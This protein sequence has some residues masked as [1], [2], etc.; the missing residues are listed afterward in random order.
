[1]KEKDKNGQ[2]ET[3]AAKTEE[4]IEETAEQSKEEVN[5]PDTETSEDA[6]TDE[7]TATAEDTAED[8]ET[9]EKGK[10]GSVKKEKKHGFKKY[11]HSTKFKHGSL[12]T[13]FSVGFIVVVVLINIIV[14]ILSDK[15]PSM[16]LDMTKNGSNS[17]SAE[18]IKVVDNVKIPVTI[19]ILAAEKDIASDTEYSQV[20]SLSAKIAERNSNI[21]VEYVDLD[22]NPTFAAEYKDESLVKGDVLVKSAKRYRLLTSSDL[23]TQQYSSD[24]STTET[25]SNVDGKLASALNTVISEKLPV[26]A[27]DTGHKEGLDATAYKSLLTNNSFKSEDFSLLTDSIPKNTQL[28]V[29]GCPTTDFTDSEID[30]LDKFLSDKTLAADRSIL[31]TS[32]AGQSE[33]PKLAAFLKEWGISVTA[34][35]AIME[36]DNSKYWD[37]Q[38]NYS[39]F[40]LFSDV[41]STL[42]LGNNV[43]DYGKYFTTPLA[44]S[45]NILFDTKGTKTTYSLVK[46]SDSCYLIT[47]ETKSTEGLKKASYNVAALSQDSVK[48]SDKTYKSNIVVTGSTQMFADGVINGS[49]FGNS[50]YIAA[51]SKYATGTANSANEISVAAKSASTKD[52]SLSAAMCNFVGVWIFMILIPLIVVILGIVVYVK[53][54][55]L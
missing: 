37:N 48:V 9:D 19:Y 29:L 32:S 1:M 36:S 46:S 25:Y 35:S 51:L 17:L 3:D 38:T 42:S 41:Q 8:A 6:E 52:I 45:V 23:F 33:M 22:K 34:G 44:S 24:Y 15:F 43:S 53:R 4:N 54:R 28:L 21:K 7:S 5:A 18:S 50:K 30:K 31:V 10:K 13:A 16:N 39:A 49:N 2:K 12:S 55:R 26:A 27:F 11:I 14:G 20:N 47:S 40:N